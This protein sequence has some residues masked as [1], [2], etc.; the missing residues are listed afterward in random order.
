LPLGVKLVKKGVSRLG[1]EKSKSKADRV[2]VGDNNIRVIED[3]DISSVGASG[4]LLVTV[5]FS[6][7][8]EYDAVINRIPH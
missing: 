1:F 4:R 5:A 6:H 2:R 8:R 7:V 3:Q